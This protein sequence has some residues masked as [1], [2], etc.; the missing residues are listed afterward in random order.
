[1]RS[2]K[3]PALPGH[4]F[5]PGRIMKETLYS[6]AE[7]LSRPYSLRNS[8]FQKRDRFRKPGVTLIPEK[9][10]HSPGGRLQRIMKSLSISAA[11]ESHCP[12]PV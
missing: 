6:F 12:I 9:N 1:M 11:Y 7:F 4:F 3:L 10:G 5:Y 8:E 2:Y